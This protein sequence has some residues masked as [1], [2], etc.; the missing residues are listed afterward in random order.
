MYHFR[1]S[2]SVFS[3][4]PQQLLPNPEYALN[5]RQVI[6]FAELTAISFAVAEELLETSTFRTP[7]ALS[8][9]ACTLIV[10]VFRPAL[11]CRARYEADLRLKTTTNNTL[12]V[13]FKCQWCTTCEADS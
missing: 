7:A 11:I 6:E 12:T 2:L 8:C 3:G 10:A 5:T 9:H 4:L 13:K 1:Q